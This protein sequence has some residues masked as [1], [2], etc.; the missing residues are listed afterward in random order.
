MDSLQG[1]EGALQKRGGGVSEGEVG[2]GVDTPMGVNTP[3]HTMVPICLNSELNWE[4]SNREVI[5]F[6][7]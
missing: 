3:M 2:G 4:A 7:R 5:A 6:H 1:L